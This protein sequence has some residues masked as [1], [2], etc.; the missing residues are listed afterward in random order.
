MFGPFIVPQ[1][2]ADTD[3]YKVQLLPVMARQKPYF[4]VCSLK[5]YRDSN[6][7]MF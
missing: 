7:D 3:N 4:L 1:Y 2:L 6:A 5:E